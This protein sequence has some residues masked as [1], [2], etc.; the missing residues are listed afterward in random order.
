MRELFDFSLLT[1]PRR[2][3]FLAR[4]PR[5]KKLIATGLIAVLLFGPPLWIHG[6]LQHTAGV[7][8]TNETGLTDSAT[9]GASDNAGIEHTD[10][11]A[12]ALNN[13][14]DRA[15]KLADAPDSQ[16]N[17]Q[18]SQGGLPRIGENGAQPWHA[19]ARP[20][21]TADRRP[22]I[23]ILV[24]GLG[25]AREISDQ[26][27]NQLPPTVTLGFD[28][29]DTVVG[30]WITRA[31]Q[32][33]HEVILD[34][35]MEPFDFPN[36]DP[37]PNTLLSSLPNSDNISRMYNLMGRGAGYVGVVS[38]SGSHLTTNP[39]KLTPVLQVLH[40]RG[41]M[42]VDARVAP[43]S[44]ITDL[45]H[46]LSL[47]V[48]TI[49]QHLDSDLSPTA[50]TAALNDLEKTATL[51]GYAVGIAGVSPVVIEQIQQWAKSL[52]QHG[53]ALAPISALVK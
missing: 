25:L 4:T 43:H 47:P 17:E 42:I 45:A 46:N 34:I 11:N 24:T 15:V 16:L 6:R 5:R 18:T 44:A 12:E 37:G 19:Y 33:G 38:T 40:D 30:A 31:R 9:P 35:P 28:G 26:A 3:S 48:A 20:F 51:N 10:I 39:E 23:A 53:I 32:D 50:I 2:E 29:E 13:Q 1:T 27:I 22:R 49:T 36:S 8:P 14:D 7:K 52:P 41:L 21:N